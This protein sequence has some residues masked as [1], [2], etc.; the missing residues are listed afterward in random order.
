ME[1]S[2][3]L[4][5]IVLATLVVLV[6][7]V[8]I[9]FRTVVKTNTVHIVQSHKRTTSYGS[10]L[11]AGNVYYGWP[12]WL[13]RIGVTVI[14]LPV[15]NFDLSLK[16][17]E[18]YDKDR[19]PFKVDVASFFRIKDTTIAAQRVVS[20]EELEEQ[21]L[22]I[23]Q[24]AVRKVLASDTV[25]NIMLERSQ[26]GEAFTKEVQDQLLQWGV[27]PVK[28]MELMDI[29]DG[30]NSKVISNIMA[31][32]TSHI[33]MLSRTEVAQN[34]RAAETAE[35]EARQ[36]V[37]IRTQEAVQAVGQRTAERVK[38][39][40]IAD[41]QAR[42]EVLTQEKE[43]TGRRMEVLR[44]E[45]V[46]QAEITK[47]QEVVVAEQDKQTTVI[48][49]EGHLEA[50]K[51]EAEGIQIEGAAKASAETAI[52]LAPVEAQIKLAKEIGQNPAYQNYLATIEGLSV[53]RVVGVAQAEALQKADIKVIANTGQATEGVKNVMD[54]FS[55]KG[56]TELGAMAEA[57]AQTPM[58]KRIVSSLVG[59]ESVPP[60]PKFNGNGDTV[61][62]PSPA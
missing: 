59:N 61:H 16:D 24:G 25:D 33:E 43:T 30:G 50:K 7:G 37:D 18:A 32:K 9:L 23:V 21:L 54:L 27:E 19:V 40:G 48:R 56:G 17:Y 49:A 20:V 46:K 13:P 60:A 39:V 41:E 29:R 51:R 55:S 38:A 3:M 35:I 36:A 8:S 14:A 45:Q 47:D 28:S 58:G 10:G 12:R 1:F 26:F 31:K 52:L 57:L 5:G 44:V 53:H 34:M 42:Q 62:E 15:S 22:Q 11:D 4:A 2:W 6:L